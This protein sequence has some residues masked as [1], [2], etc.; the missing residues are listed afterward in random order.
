M[1]GGRLMGR[2]SYPLPVRPS[3]PLTRARRGSD[4]PRRGRDTGDV[5]PT[6]L[7]WAPSWARRRR[8]ARDG[9]CRV[10]LSLAAGAGFGLEALL[11][12]G[13]EALLAAFL[14]VSAGAGDAD[15][16]C[17]CAAVDNGLAV[18]PDFFEVSGAAAVGV[19]DDVE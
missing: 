9:Y 1:P 18:E 7:P 2:S 12:A 17:V 4:Q 16:V 6:R 13:L 14:A 19:A 11:A 10:E 5:R 8:R 3:T 15:A